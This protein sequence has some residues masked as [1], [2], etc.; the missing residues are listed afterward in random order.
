MRLV[1]HHHVP[2][3][4][5]HFAWC[6]CSMSY[7]FF[8]MITTFSADLHYRG[9]GWKNT[10]FYLYGY[11]ILQFYYTWK[12]QF[13]EEDRRSLSWTPP[14]KHSRWL[15]TSTTVVTA[16]TF[17]QEIESSLWPDLELFCV[18]VCRCFNV[19][20]L[21]MVAWHRHTLT[22]ISLGY[23]GLSLVTSMT[24]WHFYLLMLVSV[25]CYW[26]MTNIL[27]IYLLLIFKKFFHS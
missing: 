13:L 17:W 11:F 5:S 15:W 25:Y 12:W 24:H 20:G 14:Q 27:G 2:P 1:A 22:L 8:R 3:F 9:E 6:W 7:S 16:P 26:L 21:R 10:A 18:C 23:L 19:C 4:L